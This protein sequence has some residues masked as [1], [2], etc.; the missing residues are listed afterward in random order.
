MSSSESDWEPV[1]HQSDQ[2]RFRVDRDELREIFSFFGDWE[3]DQVEFGTDIYLLAR[4]D[5][6]H[7]KTR[8]E[9]YCLLM[10]AK[11]WAVELPKH[12]LETVAKWIQRIEVCKDFANGQTYE[13]Y[14]SAPLPKLMKQLAEWEE[15]GPGRFQRGSKRIRLIDKRHWS[16]LHE[17]EDC[18]DI[19]LSS[20]QDHVCDFANNVA[21][22]SYCR[23]MAKRAI[24]GLDKFLAKYDRYRVIL[25]S[26]SL[27]T[28]R[29]VL[30]ELLK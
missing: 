25:Q 5:R 10:V 15:Y 11:R 22:N 23:A 14:S 20:H 26:E 1:V 2:D 17:Q 3:F 19:A 4:N 29:S 8:A 12:V 27:L 9:I 16:S 30:L 24:E 21:E 6:W 13:I 28:E 18:W 7:L